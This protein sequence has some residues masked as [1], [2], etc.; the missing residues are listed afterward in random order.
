MMY[1]PIKDLKKKSD[2]ELLNLFHQGN[3]NAIAVLFARYKQKIC[4][5]IYNYVKSK[6]LTED[7]YHDIIYKIL[8]Y[9]RKNKYTD[10]GKFYSWMLQI[11]KNQI[12]DYYR[13]HKNKKYI[14]HITNDYDEE[15]NIFDILR[16]ENIN[17]TDI[18]K[19]LANNEINKKNKNIIKKLIEKLPTEQKEVVILRVYY[20]MSFKEIA[21]FSNVSINTSLGR[22][23]Y[24][25]MNLEKMIKEKALSNQLSCM[26]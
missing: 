10:Q 3:Q 25:L 5:H 15:I 6:E 1:I 22:M 11:A 9:L 20:D 7:L 23:R 13:T 16:T 2:S 26:I 21:K 18:S 17:E 12:I 19:E 4:Y 8:I 14:S 24:A